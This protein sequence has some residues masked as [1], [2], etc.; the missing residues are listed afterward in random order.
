M[1]FT[2]YA[3]V[4]SG[5]VARH[6]RHYLSVLQLP[7]VTWSR[8]TGTDFSAS[9]A[10]ASHILLAVS[11]PA[12]SEL[13]AQAPPHK[14][15][16]HFSGSQKVA[17]TFCAHPLMTFGSDLQAEG[18][19]RGIPFVVDKGVDFARVLPGFPNRSFEVEP[20]QRAL[21]HALC[22]LAGN[23]TFML[24]RN[25]SAEFRKLELPPE[26]LA[27]FL[28]QVVNNAFRSDAVATGPVA[29]QDWRA[30]KAHLD[31]LQSHPSLAAAYR[32]FL[33]QA[34]FSGHKV[35]EALL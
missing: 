33:N 21:Y 2:S 22:A 28:H 29:R 27:P 26:I 30:V 32:D 9:V 1:K 13:A 20:E 34:V 31:S 15:L 17:G 24:W 14:T 16:I 6:L 11:D 4:G 18:W 10:S 5:R 19:Y 7:F 35:P 8:S 25:I 12:I 23:S 3:L